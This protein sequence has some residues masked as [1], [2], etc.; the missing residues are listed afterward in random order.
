MTFV[1]RLQSHLGCNFAEGCQII[2]NADG[3]FLNL[4]LFKN[5]GLIRFFR[6]VSYFSDMIVLRF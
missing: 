2:I 5:K 4:N 1:V 6:I 3:T